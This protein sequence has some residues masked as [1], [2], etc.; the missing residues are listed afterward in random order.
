ME[1][2]QTG[3]VTGGKLYLRERPATKSKRLTLIPDGT[4]IAVSDHDAQWYK[5]QYNGHNGYVMKQFVQLMPALPDAW[6][7]G[8]VTVD[9]LTVR[10]RPSTSAA[11]WNGP[12]PKGRIALIKP[13]M[14]GWYE[15]RYRGEVAYVSAQHVL[16]LAVDVSD[17]LVDRMQYMAAAEIGRSDSRYFNGYTG[18]WCH[19]FA[20]WLAM[21]AGL[22]KDRIPNT[23]GCG[24]GIVWFATDAKSGGFFFKS[25]EHK[26]RMMHKYAALKALDTSL[27]AAERDCVPQPGDYVYFRWS[28]ATS[29][30][31]VSHVGIVMDVE[32]GLIV[33]V[34]G[35]AG[36]KVGERI[37]DLDDPRIVGYG[38]LIYALSEPRD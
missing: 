30:V 17:S 19:R 1:K 32:D 18:A 25:A 28:N 7:Y 24:K 21:H 34:E 11:R 13:C 14:A 10:R 27:T 36:G 20:D 35:N 9:P 37:Y 5:A 6:T 8:K 33:T 3:I 26:K 15:T 29:S 4:Y 16:P 12:W 22:P 38:R 2:I 23:S 31:T